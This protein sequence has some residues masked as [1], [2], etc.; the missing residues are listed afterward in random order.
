MLAI[1][2]EKLLENNTSN[3][4]KRIT[5]LISFSF[6]AIFTFLFMYYYYF[7]KGA[8]VS[9]SLSKTT[10]LILGSLFAALGYSIFLLIAIFVLNKFGFKSLYLCT[11][12]HYII[13]TIIGVSDKRA[14]TYGVSIIIIQHLI[15]IAITILMAMFILKINKKFY[16]KN[17]N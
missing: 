16:L 13:M 6:I 14:P 17:V 15:G 2:K 3:L 1:I 9:G 12:I 5:F 10:L 11:L 7:I 4:K 8:E